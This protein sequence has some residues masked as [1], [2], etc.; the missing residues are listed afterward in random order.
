[1]RNGSATPIY[2]GPCGLETFTFD[3]GAHPDDT[4]TL[5]V[6][7]IDGAGN[8][9]DPATD[10]FVLDRS[11]PNAPPT[12]TFTSSCS[13]LSCNF[14]GSGSA[15]SDGTIVTYTWDYGDGTVTIGSGTCPCWKYSW[16]TYSASGSYTVTLTVTDNAEATA[17]ASKPVT[18]AVNAAPTARFTFSCAGSS[19]SFDGS[20]SADS[21]GTIQ[22]YRWDFGDGVSASGS[23]SQH[24]YPAAGTYTATLRV[25]D[26]DGATAAD[27]KTVGLVTNLTVKASKV[28]GLWKVDLAWSGP[29]GAT[30][31]VYRDGVRIASGVQATT[32]TDTIDQKGPASHTYKVCAAGTSTCSNTATVRF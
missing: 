12:A 27:S 26:N 3:L 14:D 23:G 11:I 1:V 4:Y 15:D 31:D 8:I 24:T 6:I 19:C 18:V 10:S 32:Y 20:G 22:A 30:F 5:S 29:S 9:S 13:E 28:K 25:T 7:L 21:D 2:S 16:H 17:S